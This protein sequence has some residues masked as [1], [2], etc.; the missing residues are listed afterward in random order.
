MQINAQEHK[1]SLSSIYYPTRDTKRRYKVKIIAKSGK[2]KKTT[3]A[4]ATSVADI[5]NAISFG[6]MNQ[7]MV[8]A[9]HPSVILNSDATQYAAA[10]DCHE[11]VQVIFV[12]K[13]DP[14]QVDRGDK[15]G[16]NILPDNL[17]G[18]LIQFFILRLVVKF[19]N[20]WELYDQDFDEENIEKHQLKII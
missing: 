9:V 11:N 18:S 8:N 2:G 17:V 19:K 7:I 14:Y 16:N 13:S 10:L 5:R 15:I 6:V 4:R 3:A 12:A 1:K 20:Q